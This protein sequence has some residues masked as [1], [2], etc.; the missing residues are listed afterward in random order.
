M[1]PKEKT[2]RHLNCIG[3]DYFNI[4]IRRVDI[5]S[6]IYTVNI[7]NLVKESKF[8]SNITIH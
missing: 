7:T 5:T 1:N 8:N 6:I 4:K 3:K 2:H